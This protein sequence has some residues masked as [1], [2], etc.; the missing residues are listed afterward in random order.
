MQETKYRKDQKENLIEQ[1]SNAKLFI[2]KNK[3]R[4]I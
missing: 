3:I 1:K 4:L 2:S